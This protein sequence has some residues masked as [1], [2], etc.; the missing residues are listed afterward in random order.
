MGNIYGTGAQGQGSSVP[1]DYSNKQACNK[2]GTFLKTAGIIALVM[3][4]PFI[5]PIVLFMA[6]A[7]VAVVA[8]MFGAMHEAAPWILLGLVFCFIKPLKQRLSGQQ[9]NNELLERINVLE[10]ELAEARK[11]IFE[12]EEGADFH[13]RLAESSKKGT[14]NNDFPVYVN[15]SVTNA[16]NISAPPR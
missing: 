12:L 2:D 11:Q 9:Q 6:L 15:L 13:R 3:A 7:V 14:V 5:V 10:G 8:L 1:V 4:S 16:K